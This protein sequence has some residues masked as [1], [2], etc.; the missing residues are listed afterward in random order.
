MSWRS[1]PGKNKVEKVRSALTQIQ[2]ETLHND[3][4]LQQLWGFLS[5]P[6]TSRVFISPDIIL[7]LTRKACVETIRIKVTSGQI[8]KYAILDCCHRLLYFT[9]NMQITWNMCVAIAT[10]TTSNAFPL[11]FELLHW[12]LSFS[13]SSR[14]GKWKVLRLYW[15]R[16]RECLFNVVH[17]YLDYYWLTS[18]H[19]FRHVYNTQ[20]WV[21]FNKTRRF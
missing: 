13:Y 3:L 14:W 9:L 10:K 7:V 19:V 11:F 2:I 18:C 15:R 5:K 8:L 21:F 17:Y 4:F 6:I 16:S 12:R 20:F 1:N